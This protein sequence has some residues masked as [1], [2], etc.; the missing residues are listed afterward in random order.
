MTIAVAVRTG[1]AVVFAADSK[2]T[3][4]GIVGIEEN[5]DPRWVEQT[6]DNATKVVHDASRSIVALVAGEAN[7]GQETAMDFIMSRDLRELGSA[8]NQESELSSLIES[9]VARKKEYWGET[10]IEAENWPG[11]TLLLAVP[12]V[13]GKIPRTWR[14]DLRGKGSEMQEILTFPTIWLEGS[15]NEV[16]G[17]LYGY[18]PNVLGGIA[19]TLGIDGEKMAEATR[20]LR[21]LRPVDKLSLWSMPIQDAIDLAVFLAK[22]QVEMDRFL[23]GQPACGGPID[24]MVLRMVPERAIVSFPGKTLHHPLNRSGYGE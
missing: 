4:S 3:T 8:P 10:K 2:V 15:Y 7:I 16:F 9:M 24:V 12:A 20:G 21:V 5:G 18:E 19:N 22:V 11:P 17:L 1:S 6:Y 14:V 23:P 13:G